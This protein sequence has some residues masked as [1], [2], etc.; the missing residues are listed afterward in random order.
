M[1]RRVRWCCEER[2]ACRAE[3]AVELGDGSPP[4]T[5]RGL[6]FQAAE[7]IHGADYAPRRRELGACLPVHEVDRIGAIA[8]SGQPDLIGPV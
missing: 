1:E 3:G 2:S 7:E 4:D 5:D 6:A 8:A